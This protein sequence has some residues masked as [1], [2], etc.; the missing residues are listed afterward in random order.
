MKVRKEES[1]QKTFQ[2]DSSSIE[3]KKKK[4]QFH[5]LS[6]ARY[7]TKNL[8][9]TLRSILAFS[10]GRFVGL[11]AGSFVCWEQCDQIIFGQ[12]LQTFGD[13]FLVTPV[14][15]EGDSRH[16][17]Q[18]GGDYFRNSHFKLHIFMATSLNMRPYVRG[19]NFYAANFI[20]IIESCYYRT[21]QML[22]QQLT[23]FIVMMVV[24]VSWLAG[25]HP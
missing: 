14:G 2:R 15:R 20:E 1:R 8:K 6:R 9:T 24:V 11:L 13:F 23:S 16:S 18:R 5:N 12:L 7:F 19:G 3:G 10:G 21:L 4:Q 17:Q 25:Y 22:K